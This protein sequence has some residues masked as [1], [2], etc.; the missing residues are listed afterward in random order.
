MVMN[1]NTTA[2]NAALRIDNVEELSW[3][4]MD[5]NISDADLQKLEQLLREDVDCR[6]R[7]LDCVKLHC[8]LK[9]FFKAGSEEQKATPNSAMLGMLSRGLPTSGSTSLQR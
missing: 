9:S 1:S 8:E 7:Y 4:L 2:D 6:Q 3:R 5:E